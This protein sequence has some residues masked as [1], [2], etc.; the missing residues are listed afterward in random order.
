MLPKKYRLQYRKDFARIYKKGKFLRTLLFNIKYL[1][2]NLDCSRFAF[3]IST[4][5]SKKAT[6]RN[7][8][9]RQLRA[10]IREKIKNL[11]NN[12]DLIIIAQTKILNQKFTTLQEELT[13]A[14]KKLRLLV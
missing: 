10:I 14:L 4:K 6:E 2:N 8:I 7:K 13:K 12:Y 1:K 9:K 3:V 5:I 11:Q